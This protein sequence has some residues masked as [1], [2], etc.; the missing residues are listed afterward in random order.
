MYLS[1]IIDA[2]VILI[3]V[4]CINRSMKKGFIKAS[5]ALLSVVLTFVLMFMF[6]DAMHDKI[7]NSAVGET[8]KERIT[9]SVSLSVEKE[10]PEAT[11]EQALESAGVPGFISKLIP[12]TAEKIKDTK[13]ELIEKTSESLTSSA[14]NIL[15]VIILYIIVRIALFVILRILNAVFRLPGLNSVNRLLG[16]LIGIVHAL[17]IVYVIC[18]V[19]VWFVPAKNAQTVND[20]VSRSY[21]TKYFYNDNLL[22]K[23]FIR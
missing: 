2:A 4:I 23:P 13:Q 21:I 10:P 3:F 20:A 9:A 22:V 8:I 18:A 19:M 15:S 7:E 5:G 6:N 14:I 17:F 1:L 12:K 11:G 16:A